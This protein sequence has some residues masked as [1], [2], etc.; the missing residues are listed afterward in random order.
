MAAKH[1][2]AKRPL[3]APAD[4]A[5]LLGV[6]SGRLNHDRMQAWVYFGLLYLMQQEM[7]GAAAEARVA[8]VE[9]MLREGHEIDVPTL[10]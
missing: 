6:L 1:T 3:A 2:T 8:E 4:H 7:P 10:Q 5:Y 9:K